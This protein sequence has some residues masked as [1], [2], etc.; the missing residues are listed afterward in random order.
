MTQ[1]SGLKPI[2]RAEHI[3]SLLRPL[4]LRAAF[5]QL[6]AGRVSPEEFVEVQN[7]AVLDVVAMQESIGLP[8]VTDGEF[9]RTSYWS[10]LVEAVDGLGVAPARFKFRD[11]AGNQTEFLSPH[12]ESRIKRAKSYS[13]LEAGFLLAATNVAAKVTMPSPSTMHFWNDN[14]YLQRGIY[15]DASEYFHDLAQVYQEEI[16]VLTAL[17]VRYIQLDEVPLA[18]LCDPSIRQALA[19]SG[20][21]PE[22]LVGAYIGLL[23]DCVK[24]RGD[25]VKIGV[26]LCRG[27][28]KGLWLTQGGYD[29]VA[30]RM[31]NEVDADVFLLEYD[32]PRAGGFAPLSHV[33]KEKQVVLGLISSK[34][35]QLE[36]VDSLRRRIDEAAKF[37]PLDQLAIS[38]QCGF[39]SAV[40]ANPVT[41]KDQEAKLKL[42]KK[43]ADLVWA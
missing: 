19:E 3:G 11:D 5:R 24:G 37:I 9:R 15:S 34:A 6:N 12:I 30:D 1:Q 29:H 38:P 17:G 43:T 36:D 27:N 42:V 18:M 26:H 40:T 21:E 23:N 14:Q 25:A 8:C 22:A 31:F 32:T 16:A 4:Q 33:P 41:N 10:H 35:P 28:F 7:A 13:S 20:E 2:F 39:A